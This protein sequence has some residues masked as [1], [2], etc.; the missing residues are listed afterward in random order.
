MLITL[1]AFEIIL[2]GLTMFTTRMVEHKFSSIEASLGMY[3]NKRTYKTKADIRFIEMMIEEYKRLCSDTDEEPELASAISLK[4]HKEYIGR[5]SYMSVMNIANKTKYLM[6]GIFVAEVLIAWINQEASKGRVLV[7]IF[8]SLL[9]TVMMCFYSIV[10]GLNEK[11]ETLID[12]VIHYIRNVY[13][14]E[15]RKQKK[16]EQKNI[17]DNYK[18]QNTTSIDELDSVK[19]M[20]K[21]LHE[22][23]QSNPM[24]GNKVI[25]I[26]QKENQRKSTTDKPRSSISQKSLELSAKDIA[27]LL[28]DL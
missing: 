15:I 4:L 13:P 20:V 19:P 6:W 12:E 1:F 8:S 2:I 23:E 27:Q 21:E 10:K 7:I 18:K 9:L 16:L 14:M 11:Q 22:L 24:Q 5:F 28:K 17:A 3:C 25:Q 26:A